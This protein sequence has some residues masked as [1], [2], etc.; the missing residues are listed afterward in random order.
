MNFDRY[1]SRCAPRP[2]TAVQ[3]HLLHADGNRP[4]KALCAGR[5]PSPTQK[6]ILR[7]AQADRWP[8]AFVPI[9]IGLPR[10]Y[11]PGVGL[12]RRKR[13]SSGRRRP[14]VGRRP[15]RPNSF[16]AQAERGPK[17][18]VPIEIGP[19]RRCTPSVGLRRR[20]RQ[21]SSRRRLT[22]GR[23]PPQAEFIRHAGRPLAEGLR[24]D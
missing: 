21:S 7:S 14:T 23:R 24:A 3:I 18:F 2:S 13:Q 17:A 9:E 10:R 15:P 1:P 4:S 20:K 22:V 6:T 5:R 16:G 19:S 8:K 12:R 11:A